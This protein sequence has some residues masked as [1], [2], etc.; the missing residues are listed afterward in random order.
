MPTLAS[1]CQLSSLQFYSHA[2][3]LYCSL[4]VV[5]HPRQASQVYQRV[6]PRSPIIKAWEDTLLSFEHLIAS[7]ENGIELQ[8]SVFASST[9]RIVVTAKRNST[10]KFGFPI[11]IPFFSAFG[12]AE[13]LCRVACWSWAANGWLSAAGQSSADEVNQLTASS[14]LCWPRP[15]NW[16]FRIS[17]KLRIHDRWHVLQS[18]MMLLIGHPVCGLRRYATPNWIWHLRLLP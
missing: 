4:P 9:K 12:A 8:P 11:M 7:T 14:W 16:A 13:Y 17:N 1:T 18:K 2:S 5:A 3:A 15:L 10:D 6:T